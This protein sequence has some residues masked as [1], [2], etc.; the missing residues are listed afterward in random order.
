MAR[1][2]AA[3]LLAI[4]DERTASMPHCTSL[5][6]PATAPG[7]AACA[8]CG[9]SV[10]AVRLDDPAGVVVFHP[11][12]LARR[13]PQDAFVAVLAALALVLVPPVLVWAG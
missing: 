12:C 5:D 7:A 2:A 13:I 6:R 10:G 9:L 8:L 1:R 3:S 11:S 4:P